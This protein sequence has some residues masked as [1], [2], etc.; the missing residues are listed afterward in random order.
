MKTILKLNDYLKF[1]PLLLL[2]TIICITK[3][4]NIFVG[5][6]ERY[7]IYADNLLNGFYAG[8]SSEYIFLWNGP[9][10]SILL[11]FFRFFSIPLVIAKGCNGIFIYFGLVYLFKTL[12]CFSS[13]KIGVSYCPCSWFILSVFIRFHSSLIN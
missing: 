10:Y 1:L 13:E 9:G 8:T 4:Q 12:K 5:D 2:Y 11:M 6:E 7:V 3:Q